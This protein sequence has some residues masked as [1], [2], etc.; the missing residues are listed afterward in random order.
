MINSTLVQLARFTLSGFANTGMGLA[1]IYIAM[2]LGAQYIIA[3][4]L[5]YA[6][7]LVC[8]FF[9]NRVWTFKVKSKHAHKDILP[10]VVVALTA[11]ALNLATVVSLV[12][13]LRIP[14]PQSQLAGVVVYAICSFLGMK[15]IVFS[16]DRS[17]E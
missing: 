9:I 13:V 14:A 15:Y 17:T 2:A 16:A 5:G 4:A 12:E 6:I 1:A 3:N 10:F 11:Y 8:S 7:G